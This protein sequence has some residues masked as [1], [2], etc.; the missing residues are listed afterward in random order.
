VAYLRLEDAR[1]AFRRRHPG[2]AQTP[3]VAASILRKAVT[4]SA[5]Q[6]FDIFLSHS[7]T[8]AVLIA[9]VTAYLEGQRLTVYVDWIEDAQLDRTRVTPATAALLRTRM[10]ASDSMM[11]AT[12]ETSPASKWMPWELGYFD[13]LRS[14]RV[15]ILPLVAA[16]DSEFKGQ[17]YLGLYPKIEK[18]SSDGQMKAF[19]TQGAGSRRYMSVTDFKQGKTAFRSY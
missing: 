6:S 11:Y 1:A 2:V 10:R 12:S 17:E 15:A 18:L 4:A 7:L 14:G 3:D 16:S 19:V 9:G 13:G 5:G 8:D